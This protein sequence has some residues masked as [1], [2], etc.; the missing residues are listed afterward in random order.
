MP[1]IPSFK[2]RVLV[3]KFEK[4]GYKKDHQTGSHIIL[5]HPKTKKRIV[6]PM[7]VRE[8]PR[9]TLIAIIKQSGITKEEFM[10]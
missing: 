9:G 1:R 4:F 6:I 3:K 8:L 5:Y 2:P 7:H 10:K